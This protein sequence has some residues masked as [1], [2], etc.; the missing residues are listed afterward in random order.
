MIIQNHNTVAVPKSFKVEKDGLLET[1]GISLLRGQFGDM[2]K[3]WLLLL[4]T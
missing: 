3:S 1:N 4:E 2:D